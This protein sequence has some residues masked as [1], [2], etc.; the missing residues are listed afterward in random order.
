MSKVREPWDNDRELMNRNGTLFVYNSIGVIVAEVFSYQDLDG[1]NKVFENA[2][3]IVACVNACKDI[4]SEALNAGYI[5][6]LVET[7]KKRHRFLC[8]ISD[9]KKE[10]TYNGE[11]VLEES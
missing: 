10:Y 1:M 7:D 9:V 11:K 8:S 2:K 4:S 3:R 6:H 5:Q